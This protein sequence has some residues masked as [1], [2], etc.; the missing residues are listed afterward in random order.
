MRK[1][2][3]LILLSVAVCVSLCA[4]QAGQTDEKSAD[5]AINVSSSVEIDN[6][7]ASAV[8]DP[9][10]YYNAEDNVAYDVSG[11]YN[12][13]FI[14][15]YLAAHP[16][17]GAVL[18][19]PGGGYNHLSND[20]LS[21]GSNNDGDQ[22]EASSITPWFNEAGIS[23]FVVNYRTT[24][25]EKTLDYH[26]LLS[27]ATRAMRYIRS[28]AK[29]F[30]V[31]ENKIGA[32]GYSA[33]G[34]LAAMLATAY[35][36]EVDDPDYIKD[37][38]DELSAKS[39][40]GVFSYAVLSFMNGSTHAGTRRVFTGDDA[41][42]YEKYSPEKLVNADTSPCFCWCEENDKTVPSASTYDFELALE[43]AGVKYES[44][45]FTDQGASLH[46]IGVAQ[47]YEQAKQWPTLATAFL[48]EI[49]F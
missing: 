15:P 21:K 42:L 34:H 36:W 39:N 5:S 18:V 25:V 1:S 26:Q 43:Q 16:T 17:G 9:L 6:T 35:E 40:A 47:E 37:D 38:I 46:G 44:H 23:V 31:D 4:C 28:R 30:Y 24:S 8:H 20:S 22:K 11:L 14:T 49:G 3:F 32:L 10:Y 12:C 33:G 27:D 29:E 41:S 45:V 48:K 7:K 2:L 19:F 13:C